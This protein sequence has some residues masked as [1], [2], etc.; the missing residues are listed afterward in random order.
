MQAEPAVIAGWETFYVIVGSAGGALTGLLFV[1][2]AL[3]ADRVRATTS[4]GLSAFTTPSMFHFI[5]VLAISALATMPRKGLGSLAVLLAIVALI[6]AAVT[7]LAIVHIHQF[8]EYE[9]VAEDWIWHGL[10]P[11]LAYAV[12]LVDA[13][14]LRSASDIAL[15]GIGSVSLA[16]LFVGIHNAWDVALYS[17]TTLPKKENTPSE[18]S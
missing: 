2:V 17:A 9:A 12:L 4:R 15:Y 14:M 11:G 1:V 5:N 13:I 6:G 10:I 8:D 18:K 7:I 3:V 16:L